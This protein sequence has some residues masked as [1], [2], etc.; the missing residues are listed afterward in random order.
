M[1]SP[2]GVPEI[3]AL[4]AAG[5]FQRLQGALHGGVH[6]AQA[7]Q[8]DS[9]PEPDESEGQS[10]EEEALGKTQKERHH[11]DMIYHDKH[12]NTSK[13]TYIVSFCF[14]YNY[15]KKDLLQPYGISSSP[16]GGATSF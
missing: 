8:I 11:V 2:P 5:V 13:H 14:K 1:A 16:S 10:E 7:F 9:L 3:E 15:N 4:Q 6:Q 12:G